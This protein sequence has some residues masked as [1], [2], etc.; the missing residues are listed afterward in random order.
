[1]STLSKGISMFLLS[2]IIMA[3]LITTLLG[4]MLGFSHP[5]PWILIAFLILIPYIHEKIISRQ[6][7]EWD[8]SMDTGIELIDTDHKILI[9]L[10]NQLQNATDYKVDENNIDKIMDELLNYT[11]YHFE[12]EEL[13]MRDN[14]YPGY[15]QHKQLHQNMILKMD[16]CMQTYKSNPENTIDKTLNFLKHW[17]IN[18]IKGDDKQYIPYLK[19]NKSNDLDL[20]LTN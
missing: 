2:V 18:H 5:L 7:I 3:L 15:K 12:R 11:L 1:M 19:N 10:I 9:G 20:D 4:F 13:L 14:N 6:Y 8:S 16:E 17:L